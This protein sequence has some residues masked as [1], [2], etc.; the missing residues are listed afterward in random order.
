MAAV[1]VEGLVKKFK[2]TTALAGVDLAVPE[3]TVLG[4]LGPNGAGKTTVVRILSTLLRAD[5]G[6]HGSSARMSSR[7][8]TKCDLALWA[9]AVGFVEPQRVVARATLQV[10]D[11]DVGDGRCAAHHLG[12]VQGDD[13][14]GRAAHR[15]AVVA[16]V[17][18]DLQ[19]TLLEADG[20]AALAGTAKST[21]AQA[22]PMTPPVARSDLRRG[23]S[24]L[25]I[26]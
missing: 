24:W 20:V 23:S 1:E 18:D 2:E 25:F 11:G 4:L 19:H 15:E 17:A 26:G 8:P 13:P 3:G 9:W 16:R 6:R 7:T 10:N 21:P 12:T 5:A 14:G 22:I